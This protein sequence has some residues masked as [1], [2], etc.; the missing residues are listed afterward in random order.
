MKI[1]QVFLFGIIL[2]VV[3]ISGY[4]S[5][6]V[7]IRLDSSN[8]SEN[9]SNRDLTAIIGDSNFV[10]F[11]PQL[12]LSA[13]GGE[14]TFTID[15]R[16]DSSVSIDSVSI[17]AMNNAGGVN[18]KQNNFIRHAIYK[19]TDG[20]LEWEIILDRQPDTNI[21][22][23]DIETGGL[24]FFFQD[25]ARIDSAIRANTVFPDSTIFSWAVFHSTQRNNYRIINK[26]DTTIRNYKTGKAFHIFRPKAFDN[27][28]ASTWC[29]LNIDTLSEK[30]IITIP[31]DFLENASYPVSIDPTI[32]ETSTGLWF[33]NATNL[34]YA[35]YYTHDTPTA[36]GELSKVYLY[37][38][39]SNASSA[40]STRGYVYDYD[41]TLSNCDL[42]ASSSIIAVTN[43]TT[44]GEAQWNEMDIS[45]SISSSTEYMPAFRTN[46]NDLQVGY[47]FGSPG[48][49]KYLTLNNWTAPGTL[50]GAGD[51][52]NHWAC[53]FEYTIIADSYR[54]RRLLSGGQ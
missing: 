48:D 26:A 25:T 54:R 1:L 33:A 3:Q 2:T 29:E 16:T 19:R 27:D 37:S 13:W 24:Q 4:A 35:L 21:F 30:L 18:I 31:N 10:S 43:G 50:N 5:E 20:N 12:K 47:G 41:A 53:Y 28:K 51:Y 45:G 22:E 9:V 32:G 46:H 39:R 17:T 40:C 7:V 42:I 44:S 14:C 34:L 8:S 23:F 36:D 38:Y 15:L 6:C 49:V 11:R 52:G